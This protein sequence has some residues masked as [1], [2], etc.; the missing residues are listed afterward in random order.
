MPYV[1]PWLDVTPQTFTGAMEAGTR[2]GLAERSQSAQES[3]AGD[4]LRLA[5]DSLAS[6]ERMQ[7]QTAQARLAQNQAAMALR[8]AQME[9]LQDYRRQEEE[10]RRNALE[11]RGEYQ[12][13]RLDLMQQGLDLQSKRADDAVK[14]SE[15]LNDRV[16]AHQALLAQKPDTFI[17][18]EHNHVLSRMA[19]VQRALDRNPSE[20]AKKGL[21]EE[22]NGLRDKQAQLE[23][24]A[25][26]ATTTTAT[27][28]ASAVKTPAAAIEHLKKN[29]GLARQF[30][31]KYGEGAAEAILGQ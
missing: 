8:Q 29:P 3:E 16:K 31:A 1:P 5:Y 6:H 24:K 9:G 19:E 18:Q 21:V 20:D 14:R 12:G 28:P 23:S 27:T 4:R 2:A 25:K 7:N 15:E 13:Q 17:A 22:W 30:D 10:R 11:Q 26:A